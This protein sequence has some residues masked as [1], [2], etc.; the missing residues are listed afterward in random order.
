MIHRHNREKT[1]DISSG[2]HRTIERLG[3]KVISSVDDGRGKVKEKGAAVF[4]GFVSLF[5]NK[6][7]AL[8]LAPAVREELLAAVEFAEERTLEKVQAQAALKLLGIL[9]LHLVAA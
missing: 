3:P 4:L 8:L 1:I 5:K 9:Y 7:P 2:A 6:L